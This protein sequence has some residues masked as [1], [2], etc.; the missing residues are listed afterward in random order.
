MAGSSPLGHIDLL[1]VGLLGGAIAAAWRFVEADREQKER[2]A[3][4]GLARAQQLHDAQREAFRRVVRCYNAVKSIRRTLRSLGFTANA[5]SLDQE[6]AD[7]FR[8]QMLRLNEVQLEFEALTRD[9][10]EFKPVP[11]AHDRRR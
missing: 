3:A 6:Q 7:R 11:G 8:E 5:G 1:S 9:L 10:G 4:D 2:A